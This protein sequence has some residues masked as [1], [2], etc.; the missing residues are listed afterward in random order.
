[1]YR[2]EAKGSTIA[3]QPQSWAVTMDK[4]NRIGGECDFTTRG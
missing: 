3:G 2:F 4:S 1:M